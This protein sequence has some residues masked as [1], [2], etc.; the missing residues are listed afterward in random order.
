MRTLLPAH[1]RELQVCGLERNEC[2][3]SESTNTQALLQALLLATLNPEVAPVP[4]LNVLLFFCSVMF[5][6]VMV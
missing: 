4:V 5:V 2:W 3:V 1:R 6:S